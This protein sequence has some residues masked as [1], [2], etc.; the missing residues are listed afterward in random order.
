MSAP[1][2]PVTEAASETL[3]LLKQI[4]AS[5]N[6]QVELLEQIAR[7]TEPAL[8]VLGGSPGVSANWHDG[9]LI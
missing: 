7:N 4:L 5:Q 6:R 9:E 3:D 2:L 1:P 8:S